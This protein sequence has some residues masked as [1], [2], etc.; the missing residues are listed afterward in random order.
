MKSIFIPL[1]SVLVALTSCG[2]KET[3]RPGAARRIPAAVQA[4]TAS[5]E[6]WPEIYEATGT[7]RARTSATLSSKMTG[8]VQQVNFQVGDRVLQGE[9]L[10]VLDARDLDANYRR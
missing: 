6:D 7:V 5:L 10:I 8:Y 4:A 1:V 9:T 2:S 3:P